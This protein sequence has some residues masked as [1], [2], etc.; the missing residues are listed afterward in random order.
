LTWRCV[1][2]M[3]LARVIPGLIFE[4]LRRKVQ[5]SCAWDS[6]T[7]IRR[8]NLGCGKLCGKVCQPFLRTTH[9]QA[10]SSKKSFFENVVFAC[11]KRR[12]PFA[13]SW[14][15]VPCTSWDTAGQ[16]WP[17]PR[18]A[19][20]EVALTQKPPGSSP[21]GFLF[22]SLFRSVLLALW[23]FIFSHHRAR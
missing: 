5:I 6:G 16:R 3:L 13:Y 9:R 20:G 23:F 14:L 2:D 11:G 1:C 12:K 19:V 8:D 18:I 4:N 10:R 21:D 22:S 7:S 17:Q 15:R